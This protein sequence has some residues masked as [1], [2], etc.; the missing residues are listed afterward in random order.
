MII[1]QTPLRISFFGGGTDF[2][3]Y[4]KEHCGI[5]ISTC[6]NKFIYFI[7]CSRQDKKIVLNYSK[8][9]I[10]DDV[11]NI[12][13]DIFREVLNLCNIDKSIEITCISD[14]H[15]EG[16]GLGSSSAFCVGLFNAIYAYQGVA[17][18]PNELA[19][20]AY[21]IEV[22][23][24]K[25]PIGKQDQFAV[26]YGGLKK[27]HFNMDGSVFVDDVSSANDVYQNLDRHIVLYNTGIHRK[28]SEVLHAQKASINANL[29][30]LHNLK[31][32]AQLGEKHLAQL[33]YKEIGRLL[34]TSWEQKKTL[35]D[36]IENDEINYMYRK[37]KQAGAYGGKLLGAGGGGFL[38]FFC[39]PEK[40]EDL[41]N[42]LSCYQELP[43]KMERCGS[44]VVFNN[45]SHA[46]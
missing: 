30:K 8:R 23:I 33:K 43:V 5:A 7:V 4:Y 27:Y 6:I 1:S 36:R 32:I 11:K 22:D 41:R 31:D 17:I 37:G 16:S 45:E 10:V 13:H 35:S 15:S 24:L 29:E 42:A 40:Q 14:I 44:R 21:K 19:E 12:E 20:L 46:H 2:E 38:L 3:D 25:A 9:E 34:D 39:A 28:S 18:L 26:A